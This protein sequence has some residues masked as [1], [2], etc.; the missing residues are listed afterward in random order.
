MFRHRQHCNA[1]AVNRQ[2]TCLLLLYRVVISIYT[3]QSLRVPPKLVVACV[4][5][6]DSGTVVAACDF[7]SA[8]RVCLGGAGSEQSR[9][10]EEEKHLGGILRKE[11]VGVFG[12]GVS[13]VGRCCFALL[14]CTIQGHWHLAPRT[15]VSD[16]IPCRSLGTIYLEKPYTSWYLG[17]TGMVATLKVSCDVCR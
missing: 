14:D 6:D 2:T 13:V 17:R 11:R 16:R 4:C 8:L 10:D 1:L 12:C 3:C 7:S 15:H 5:V 9:E